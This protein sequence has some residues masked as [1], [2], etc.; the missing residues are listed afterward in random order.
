MSQFKKKDSFVEAGVVVSV[1]GTAV[2]EN[3]GFMIMIGLLDR[4]RNNS[5]NPS[6]ARA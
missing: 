3:D 4:T 2:D 1:L 6:D 5:R